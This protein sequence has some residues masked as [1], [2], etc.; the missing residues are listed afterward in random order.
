[1]SAKQSN[2]VFVGL[3][4]AVLVVLI[5]ALVVTYMARSRPESD[6]KVS[7]R[8][9]CYLVEGLAMY[10]Q[11]YYRRTGTVPA[12]AYEVLQG[13]DASFAE[14]YRNNGVFIIEDAQL[15]LREER[16]G[17]KRVL[18]GAIRLAPRDSKYPWIEYDVESSLFRDPY[19]FQM[20]EIPQ[21]RD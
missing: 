10:S 3:A 21:L 15:E 13:E 20:V 6:R 12:N 8:A 11:F 7:Y 4:S 5:G 14:H 19:T 16:R 2:F 9:G 18:V 1:M 17:N